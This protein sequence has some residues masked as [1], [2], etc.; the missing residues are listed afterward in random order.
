[1][2]PAMQTVAVVVGGASGIGLATAELFSCEPGWHVVIADIKGAQE[3]AATLST[4][5]NVEGALLDVTSSLAVAAFFD[6]VGKKFGRVD[7]LVNCAGIIGPEVSSEVTDE[8][9]DSMLSTH[10]GGAMRCARGAFPWMVASGKAA[11]VSTSSIGAA[12]G[13]PARAAYSAAKGG[14]E[15]LTRVLAVEWASH[16]IRVNAVAPGFTRTALVAQSIDKGR[17]DVQGVLRRVPLA[18]M[19]EPHE[20]AR[21][22]RFLCTRESSYVTGQVLTVDGGFLISGSV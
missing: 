11:L 15:S 21:A 4:R 17:V 16:G 8:S 13:V 10:L 7:V 3:I 9:W 14:I 18:R 20:I 19:A 22:I 2:N 1:M 6:H 12:V 5:S